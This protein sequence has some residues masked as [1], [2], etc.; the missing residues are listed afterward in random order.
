M[1][2]GVDVFL[3]G[4][5]YLQQG[6]AEAAHSCTVQS[7]EFLTLWVV[8]KLKE[9]GCGFYFNSWCSLPH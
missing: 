7:A 8:I 4:G 6:L 5:V 2:E 1:S 9:K 3:L